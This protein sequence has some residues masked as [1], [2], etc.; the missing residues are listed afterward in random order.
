MRTSPLD[1]DEIE[2]RLPIWVVLSALF[3]DTSIDAH[4]HDRM[5]ET[6]AQSPYSVAAIERILREDVSPAFS[7]NLLQVAGE[8]A[9]W[10][11]D[12]VRSIVTRSVERRSASGVMARLRRLATPRIFPAG[13]AEIAKRIESRRNAVQVSAV[14]RQ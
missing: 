13:W 10:H 2:W 14:Q 7:W 5:A 8:W 1:K 11:D 6:L 4:D 12:D 9:G 3:L